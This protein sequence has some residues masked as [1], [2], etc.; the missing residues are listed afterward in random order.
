MSLA[1][2]LVSASEE[3]I[4]GIENAPIRI[5]VAAST[6]L[7]VA[8]KN[9]KWAT[10]FGQASYLVPGEYLSVGGFVL[11]DIKKGIEQGYFTATPDLF[12]VNQLASVVISGVQALGKGDESI[13][14]RTAENMLSILG[15]SRAEASAI[16][17]KAQAFLR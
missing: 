10:F 2:E 16:V 5:A 11:A 6:L 1:I 8:N 9:K 13:I 12:Q 17:D 15:M 7:Q 4:A 14:D 3:K